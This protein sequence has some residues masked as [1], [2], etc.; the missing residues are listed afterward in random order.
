MSL[1]FTLPG[2]RGGLFHSSAA[3]WPWMM[4]LAAVGIGLAVDW[5]AIKLPHWQPER[6]KRLFSGIFVGIAFVLSLFVGLSRSD[7]DQ[8]AQIYEE[9]GEQLPPEAVVMVGDAPGFYYH[10]G[11]TA[12]SIPNESLDV[13]LQAAARY[14]VTYLVLDVNHPAPLTYLYDKT[15]EVSETTE[16]F[17]FTDF[18]IVA[19]Y[20]LID[21]EGNNQPLFL[22]QFNRYE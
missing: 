6:A 20:D 17:D 3:V 9:I 11:I 2:G 10:T 19:K 16:P 5:F 22:Y 8:L 15:W 18:G 12:V 13:L 4:A 21:V 7:T 14:R 1:I